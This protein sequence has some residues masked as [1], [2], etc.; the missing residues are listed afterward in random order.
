MRAVD[1]F[2]CSRFLPVSLLVLSQRK[3]GKGS[4]VGPLLTLG[5]Q[6]GNHNGT[7]IR[8]AQQRY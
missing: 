8:N 4:Q 3:A 1:S 7:L 5:M 2:V 6:V